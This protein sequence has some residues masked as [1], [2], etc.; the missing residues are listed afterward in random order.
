MSTTLNHIVENEQF[1]TEK[2]VRTTKGITVVGTV[3]VEINVDGRTYQ[4]E[5]VLRLALKPESAK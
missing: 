3:Y 4:A 1:V 5:R 2:A